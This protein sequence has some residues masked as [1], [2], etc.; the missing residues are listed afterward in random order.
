MAHSFNADP[1]D[2]KHVVSASFEGSVMLE[3]NGF[4]VS[5][6]VAI[7]HP[8]LAAFFRFFFYFRSLL[9]LI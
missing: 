8:L 5:F 6:H 4:G 1:Q 2:K 7:P 3:Q 9:V